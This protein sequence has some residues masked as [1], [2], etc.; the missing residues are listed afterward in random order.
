M[1]AAT[2]KEM[3]ASLQS[4]SMELGQKMFCKQNKPN[5]E[6]ETGTL[7]MSAAP[8]GHLQLTKIHGQ[9]Q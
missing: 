2:Y 9:W 1:Y 6:R 8:R 5:A 3:R 4:D 7:K